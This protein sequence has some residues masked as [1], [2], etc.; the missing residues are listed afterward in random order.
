MRIKGVCVRTRRE[1][2]EVREMGEGKGKI[3]EEWRK[4]CHK[5]WRE[6]EKWG[7]SEETS[8]EIRHEG[9]DKGRDAEGARK[10]LV[11]KEGRKESAEWEGKELEGRMQVRREEGAGMEKKII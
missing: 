2:K 8:L 11:S 1:Q 10:K 5:E 6:R 3:T 7:N 9:E 4:K